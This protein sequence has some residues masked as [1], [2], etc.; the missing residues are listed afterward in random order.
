MIVAVI[1]LFFFSLHTFS[2]FYLNPLRIN[3]NRIRSR[4][5]SINIIDAAIVDIAGDG[6]K[7][8]SNLDSFKFPEKQFK[9]INNLVSNSMNFFLKSLQQIVLILK[10]LINNPIA[11]KCLSAMI[12]FMFTDFIFQQIVLS[13]FKKY[14]VV[15]YYQLIKTGKISN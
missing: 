13:I 5:L 8:I 4:A 15:I 3:Y 12:G 9:C 11:K 14:K 10:I 7:N 2:C 1:L 6:N